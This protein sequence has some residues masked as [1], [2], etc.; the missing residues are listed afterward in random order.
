M[1][2]SII[3]PTFQ[4]A[5]GIAHLVTY[6]RAQTQ[7][8]PT[9]ILVVDAQSPDG[10]AALAQAAGATVLT[11]QHTSRARQ[12]NEGARQ[13]TGQ[14]LYF[15]HADTYPPADFAAAILTPIAAGKKAGCFRLEFDHPHWFLKLMGWCTRLTTTFFRFGDQSL[16]VERALFWEVNGFQETLR[17]M[18]DQEI[19]WRLHRKTTFVVLPQR[20]IS[21]ARKYLENGVIRLQLVFSLILVMYYLGFPQHTLMATYQKL[22]QQKRLKSEKHS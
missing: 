20:V 19:V 1:T 22:I 12:M 15:L 17:V 8:I 21:S 2:L 5:R 16:F 13:A 18:E 10:T 6:L 7:G 4:E 14:V 3:I 9:E 11:S